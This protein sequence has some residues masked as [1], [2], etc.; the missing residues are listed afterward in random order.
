MIG[1]EMAFAAQFRCANG[2][3]RGGLQP[4][5]SEPTERSRSRRAKASLRDVLV[6]TFLFYT[7]SRL[8]R[9]NGDG[10]GG[11]AKAFEKHPSPAV[12]EQRTIADFSTARPRRS[13][14]VA[15]KRTLIERLQEKRTALITRTVT[16]SLPPNDA[17][18]AGLDP[19]PK[20]K[21]TGIAWLGEVPEHW[22]T[23]K[24]LFGKRR[25]SALRRDGGHPLV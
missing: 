5:R 9:G 13:H 14:L 10:G 12:D 6:L 8:F 3:S 4:E 18:A 1:A 2:G 11:R 24:A 17:R 22:V 19:H 23:W 25:A 16:R 21:P 7:I 20:L 15:K